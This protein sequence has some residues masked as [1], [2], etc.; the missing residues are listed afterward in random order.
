MGQDFQKWQEAL[1]TPIEIYPL[2]WK[3]AWF[4]ESAEQPPTE[5][6]VPVSVS[7]K[8]NHPQ[9]L[10]TFENLDPTFKNSMNVVCPDIYFV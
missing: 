5:N 9:P 8:L 4:S 1:D 3:G 2:R 6:Q 10:V 7:Q